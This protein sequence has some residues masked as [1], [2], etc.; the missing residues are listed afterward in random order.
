MRGALRRPTGYGVRDP[1]ARSP[2]PGPSLLP[3]VFGCFVPLYY[4]PTGPA[5]SAGPT[6]KNRPVPIFDLQNRIRNFTR[7][8]KAFW[9]PKCSPK[10]PKIEPKSIQ[11]PLFVR[12]RFPTVFSSVS[13][14]FFVDFGRAR[15][16]IQS[17][18]TAL[19]WA[20]PFFQKSGKVSKTT[21]Q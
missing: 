16:S 15:P 9:L 14:R 4:L 6:Q 20:A 19:A 17:L 8:L 18:F 1:A 13:G 21:S 2:W 12:F 3:G 11:N 7:F 5:H 10:P